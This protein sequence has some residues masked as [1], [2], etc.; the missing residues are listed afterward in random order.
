MDWI[1]GGT[2]YKL[3]I[4]LGL[5]EPR[6]VGRACSGTARRS[7]IGVQHQNCERPIAAEGPLHIISRQKGGA[8]EGRGLGCFG[9]ASG[10]GIRWHQ[11]AM[12]DAARESAALQGAR[13]AHRPA[14]LQGMGAGDSGGHTAWLSRGLRP[15]AAE[16]WLVAGCQLAP[17][18]PS[19]ADVGAACRP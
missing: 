9:G 1:H 15:H 17:T 6:S 16:M 2:Q 14:M 13:V 11:V 5:Q 8:A 10:G 19:A 3:N 18:G 4:V 12:V 7:K